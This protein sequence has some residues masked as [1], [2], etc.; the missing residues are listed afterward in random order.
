MTASISKQPCLVYLCNVSTY[1]TGQFPTPTTTTSTFIISK[2]INHLIHDI[3]KAKL[4]QYQKNSKPKSSSWIDRR[5]CS[6]VRFRPLVLFV[7]SYYH[8]LKTTIDR[9]GTAWQGYRPLGGR[10]IH[11]ETCQHVS[12]VCRTLH[13]YI[14]V[15][16]W[17]YSMHTKIRKNCKHKT[18]QVQIPNEQRYWFIGLL[19]YCGCV[20][21]SLCVS[22][23]Q[24]FNTC[25]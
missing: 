10:A 6:G 4:I 24:R 5:L 16:L 3:S 21:L 25:V 11:S 9:L 20:W 22:P 15:S 18:Q 8:V 19:H 1:F 12:N 13:H 17:V 2:T 23:K 14:V 7:V